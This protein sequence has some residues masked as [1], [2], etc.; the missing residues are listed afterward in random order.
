MLHKVR[1][2]FL[3]YFKERDHLVL[4]SYSI[5]PDNDD[6]LLFIN[7]GM[8]PLKKFFLNIETP[9]YYNITTSQRCLRV[10]GKHNDLRDVG[11]TKRHH[12]FFEM[13]GNFSFGDYFK[14]KAIEYAWIF[15]TQH[16]NLDKTRLYVT[17]HPKDNDAMEIWSRYIAK[18]RIVGLEDNVWSMGDVGPWG[19]C[20]EIFYDLKEGTGNL[21]DGDRYL[22]IWNLV[23]MEFYSYGQ[24][25]ASLPKACIDTGMGLERIIAVL[26]GVTDTYDI[27]FFSSQLDLLNQKKQTPNTKIFL[28]HL[29]SS[30]WLIQEGITPSSNTRGYILRR[31]L[32]RMLKSGIDL[33]I[34]DYEEIIAK[35]LKN[36]SLEYKLDHEKIIKTI[37][38]E[39]EMFL[40]TY[41]QGLKHF[42]TFFDNKKTLT[43]DDIFI[44]HDRYGFLEDIVRDLVLEKEGTADFYGFEA[45]ISRNKTKNKKKLD[46]KETEYFDE[47]DQLEAT[48]IG[49]VDNNLIFDKS[50]FYAEGGGQVGDIGLGEG[51]NFKVK[52]LDTKKNGKIFLHEFEVLEG[53]IEVGDKIKLT[54]DSFR[55]TKIRAHHS[56]VHLVQYALDNLYQN[57]EQM[58]SYVSDQKFRLDFSWNSNA[59]IDI[60]KIEDY[61]RNIIKKEISTDIQYMNLNEAKASGAKAFFTYD[62]VVRVVKIDNAAELCGG[63]HISNTKDIMDIK[64][65][66]ISAVKSGVKRIEGVAGFTY[67]ETLKSENKIFNE[68]LKYLNIDQNRILALL[69]KLTD[70][71]E[72]ALNLFNHETIN[73]LKIGIVTAEKQ[74]SVEDV[75]TKFNLDMVCLIIE[76]GDKINLYIKTVGQ[77]NAKEIAK[78]IAHHYSYKGVGGKEHFAQTGGTKPSNYEEIFNIFKNFVN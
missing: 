69:K 27:T 52:I 14:E 25:S 12:T 3:E 53:T 48:V 78:E 26:E 6:S 17:I 15:I 56:C 74:Y 28:D 4:N 39:Q 77:I 13:L 59:E 32:R 44:L 40:S 63:S 9:P 64:I 50:C 42:H 31:I 45:L 16:L 72:D 46:F 30:S 60:A 10:G 51:N 61:I 43:A 57:V 54:V 65:T 24:T 38:K 35:I 23:F 36:W 5:I 37:M 75:I 2:K 68:V 47:V 7:A 58:G 55:K 8:A 33:N 18:D 22:E 34:L 62:S 21:E 19:Y 29:R 20:S 73:G 11:Y 49:I 67:L 76:K 66:K 70:K 71:E 41:N 1:G